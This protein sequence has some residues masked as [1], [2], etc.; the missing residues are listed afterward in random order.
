MART[1]VEKEA[2]SEIAPEKPKMVANVA[3]YHT[4]VRFLGLV[5]IPDRGIW[6]N[7][8]VKAHI[9]EWVNAGYE[10]QE[11]HPL[12]TSR[13]EESGQLGIGIYFLF[14]YVG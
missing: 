2:Q 10:I 5:D 3:P 14:K 13:D 1:A 8:S 6:S 11:S 12:Q 4:M 9:A 7:E